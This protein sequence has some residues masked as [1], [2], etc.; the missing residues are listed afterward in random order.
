MLLGLNLKRC[1]A[2]TPFFN[3]ASIQ[4]PNGANNANVLLTILGNAG[5]NPCGNFGK[6]RHLT[7]QCQKRKKS[8]DK[9]SAEPS[10]KK[11]KKQVSNVGEEV[12]AI[13]VASNDAN[14]FDP[15]NK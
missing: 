12:V 10:K 8:Q 7:D 9:K 2:V 15:S 13:V 6:Y 14:T 4:T 11:S 5:T 3:N 1:R